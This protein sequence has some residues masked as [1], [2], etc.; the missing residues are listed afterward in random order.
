MEKLDLEKL[1]RRVNEL[2]A[3]LDVIMYEND[4]LKYENEQLRITWGMALE[5][6]KI[7]CARWTSVFSKDE[8]L[9]RLGEEDLR[10]E[11][12][13]LPWRLDTERFNA[14]ILSQEANFRS[15]VSLNR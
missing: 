4:V 11:A 10:C 6:L 12:F 1:K 7:E 3:Q 2:E 5:A 15:L 14:V 9:E 13:R 8:L